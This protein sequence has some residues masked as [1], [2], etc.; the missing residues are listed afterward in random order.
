MRWH[1]ELGV[2]A[3]AGVLLVLASGVAAQTQQEIAFVV[4]SDGNADIYHMLG[5]GTAQTNLTDHAA[6]DTTPCWSPDGSRIA[7][8]SGRDGNREIYTMRADGS[9]LTR[10]TS[11]PD[12]DTE[13]AWSPD[14]R[15]LLFLRERGG[16]RSLWTLDVDHGHDTFLTRGEYDDMHPEWSPD[17]EW[18]LLARMGEQ[19]EVQLW[20]V[21][22]GG[23]ER[24]VQLTRDENGAS[25]GRWSP[26]GEWIVYASMRT[27]DVE[28]W[29]MRSDGTG[30]TQLTHSEGL[31]RDP[32]WSPDG[33]W[34]AFVSERDGN[35]E[36]Y[37][38]DP[39]GEEQTN[40]TQAAGF[41]GS[42]RWSDD[43]G[44]LLFGSS[45]DGGGI[46]V[47]NAD[48]SGVQML[49]GGLVSAYGRFR[50]IAA[51]EPGPVTPAAAVSTVWPEAIACMQFRAGRPEEMSGEIWLMDPDGRNA[52]MLPDVGPIAT[53]P[54]I[55]YDREW[56][57]YLRPDPA[58][59]FQSELWRCR[60]DGT[61][62]EEVTPPAL[63]IRYYRF[64]RWH[65]D[66][67]R[68]LVAFMPA[69]TADWGRGAM[70]GWVELPSLE[71]RE[72]EVN[73]LTVEL[74]PDGQRF[75]A[76][77]NGERRQDTN[78]V[79]SH[80]WITD[81][82][83]RAIRQLTTEPHA[84]DEGPGWSPDGRSIAF[85]RR[86]HIQGTVHMLPTADLCIVP[87][88]GGQPT[89]VV[90]D[91]LRPMSSSRVVW[92]PDGSRL[93]VGSSHTGE[94]RLFSV[95]LADGRVTALTEEGTSS[96][97]HDWR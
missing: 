8:V 17:G 61:L 90:A 70:Y 26:D 31:D 29:K 59:P 57:A 9:E 7:F 36:V 87:A 6:E 19:G 40:L 45:R 32:R 76:I 30:Q 16:R 44:H 28:L 37:R 82:N 66:G 4:I 71:W 13:P 2:C 65:P 85:L 94:H 78:F 83:G 68:L 81:L 39:E 5:D 80:L 48:G 11:C 93:L 74:A 12:D 33:A 67:E 24:A 60:P 63:G 86:H 10:Q 52:R 41:D 89:V 20:K 69:A 88:T 91:L 72:L 3:S 55:S 84:L 1:R 97:T 35:P 25:Y 47:M 34:I 14:G 53:C 77:R 79:A 54:V 64:I 50:P 56:I 95:T 92:S 73:A 58:A 96:E 62:Q 75:A 51:P 22:S 15:R 46:C 23:A 21:P 18:I 38:M 49:T 27:G 42:P 43:S